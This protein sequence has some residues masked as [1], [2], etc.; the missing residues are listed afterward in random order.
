MIKVLTVPTRGYG[1]EKVEITKLLKKPGDRIG[2]DEPVYELETDKATQE[3]E[4][5][6]EAVL[7]R[8]WVAEGDIV[9]VG[10]PVA[11]V[12]VEA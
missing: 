4:A 10:D 8:W 6:F 3:V 1:V 2:V 12:E 11:D 9:S 5:E 7:V